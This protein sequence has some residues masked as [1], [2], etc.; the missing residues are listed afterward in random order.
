M[1]GPRGPECGDQV[2][3]TPRPDRKCRS[4][5]PTCGGAWRGTFIA[6][7]NAH[8][9]AESAPFARKSAH[10]TSPK[11]ADCGTLKS[12][13][14][15]GPT[16]IPTPAGARRRAIVS[17]VGCVGIRVRSWTI[18]VNGF[19]LLRFVSRGAWVPGV[20]GCL[21]GVQCTNRGG[22]AHEGAMRCHFCSYSFHGGA[23][24]AVRGMKRI[25]GIQR[26]DGAHCGRSCQRRA[27]AM[28]SK[29]GDRA[30]W[31]GYFFFCQ[32]AVT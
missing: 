17:P 12:L 6:R 26:A 25:A 13:T 19:S 28:Q 20:P 32:T 14:A 8:R 30:G 4:C 1:L 16:M 15:S 18:P 22:W 2:C 21:R 23:P 9:R 27:R 24:G 11:R 3:I 31:C 29:T 10:K 5:G 7:R